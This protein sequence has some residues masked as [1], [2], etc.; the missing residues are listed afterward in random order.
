M[1]ES[2]AINIRTLYSGMQSIAGCNANPDS[3]NIHGDL[4]TYGTGP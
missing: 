4:L 3:F 1:F 2:H